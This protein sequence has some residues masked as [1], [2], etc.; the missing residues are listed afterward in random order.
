MQDRNVVQPTPQYQQG[1]AR[2]LWLAARLFLA[3]N[4][5]LKL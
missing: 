3:P 5:G 1:V 4:P 2:Y